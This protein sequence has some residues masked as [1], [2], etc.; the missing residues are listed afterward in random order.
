MSKIQK[1]NAVDYINE[2]KCEF[3][4][5]LEKEHGYFQYADH[6]KIQQYMKAFQEF[7][8]KSTDI[9]YS[10]KSCNKIING[11]KFMTE[12]DVP[13]DYDE[14]H[15]RLILK[16]GLVNYHI[17]ITQVLS[18]CDIELIETNY[19]WQEFLQD[20]GY[21][22]NNIL[23]RNCNYKNYKPQTGSP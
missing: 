9:P 13:R 2:L 7:I 16:Y 11:F 12:V 19:I 18:Y 15:Y 21:Y 20:Y 8:K 22:Y 3:C 10:K 6:K 14:S 1:K 5:E 23:S 17:S 4:K